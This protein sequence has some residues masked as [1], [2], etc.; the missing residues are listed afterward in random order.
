MLKQQYFLLDALH[1][2]LLLISPTGYSSDYLIVDTNPYFLKMFE[3][4]GTVIG[5]TTKKILPQLASKLIKQLDITNKEQTEQNSNV[6]ITGTDIY[7]DIKT[8]PGEDNTIACLILDVSKKIYYQNRFRDQNDEIQAQNEELMATNEELSV[9]LENINE[10]NL[11]LTEKEKELIYAKEKAE[12]S[13]RLKSAFLANM[14]HEIRTPMNGIIGFS[15]LLKETSISESDKNHYIKIISDNSQQLLDI[16]NDIIDISK[17]ESGEVTLNK[18]E[19]NLKNLLNKISDFYKPQASEKNLGFT[20]DYLINNDNFLYYQDATKLYQIISNLISNAIKFTDRG[21]V[22]I[23]C[24][25]E[26][27]TVCFSISDTGIG[28]PDEYKNS[29]FDRFSQ[30]YSHNNPKYSG[31]GLG[32]SICKGL[33]NLMDGNISFLSEEGKGSTFLVELPLQNYRIL[34]N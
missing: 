21:E 2:G 26:K 19:V 15:Q 7:Y 8:I 1:T 4:S 24:S 23:T 5:Q 16:V 20:A 30:G 18:R 12:E 31:T 29:I 34:A 6:H 13:D 32:L 25:L 3:C 28:I 22:K 14:S 17:I 33:L 11:I 9:S 10:T 27:D